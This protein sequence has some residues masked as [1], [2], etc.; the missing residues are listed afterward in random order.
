MMDVPFRP[1][2]TVTH[3][4]KAP[5]LGVNWKADPPGKKKNYRDEDGA[6]IREPFNVVS[7]PWRANKMAGKVLS[8]MTFD[9]V[10]RNQIPGRPDEYDIKKTL[11]RKEQEDHHAKVQDAPFSS[12]ARSKHK[13]H[14]HGL[15]NQP[16]DWLGEDRVYPPRPEKAK[17]AKVLPEIHDRP[18]NPTGFKTTNKRVHDFLG[19]WPAHMTDPPKEVKRKPVNEDAPPPFK[20]TWNKKTVP[21]PSIACNMRNIRTVGGMRR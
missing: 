2:K 17:S 6:V 20:M 21:T 14:I 10:I 15:I 8:K 5:Q 4:K 9:G 1:A 7:G 16:K 19:K 13:R 3:S 12:M 11:L 18:F